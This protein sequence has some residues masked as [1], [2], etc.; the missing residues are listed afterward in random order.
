M[1]NAVMNHQIMLAKGQFS[2]PEIF[3]PATAHL[4]E[5]P[6]RQFARKPEAPLLQGLGGTWVTSD[7][8]FPFSR[9]IIVAIDEQHAVVV[10]T[11]R[12]QE[13]INA[14]ATFAEGSLGIDPFSL[15]AELHHLVIVKNETGALVVDTVTHLAT[16]PPLITAIVGEFVPA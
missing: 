5:P 13:D 1:I 15:P 2:S 10:C 3:D 7:T 9:I 11:S 8:N 14:H 4:T 6:V 16:V 12:S